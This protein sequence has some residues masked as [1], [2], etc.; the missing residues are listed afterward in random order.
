M[1]EA[2]KDHRQPIKRMLN[3][4]NGRRARMDTQVSIR[5]ARKEDGYN[6]RRNMAA[7]AKALAELM[8]KEKSQMLHE[9]AQRCQALLI[10]LKHAEADVRRKSLRAFVYLMSSGVPPLF[11]DSDPQ[12]V[13]LWQT[14]LA[15]IP[16]FVGALDL[17]DVSMQSDAAFALRFI[18]SMDRSLYVVQSGV[19]PKM[20]VLLQCGISELQIQAAWCLGNVASESKVMCEAVVAVCPPQTVL[21]H[22]RMSTPSLRRASVWLLRS[23]IDM[24]ELLAGLGLLTPQLEGDVMTV[25]ANVMKQLVVEKTKALAKEP[26]APSPA[27]ATWRYFQM[28]S[29]RP[30]PNDI[31]LVRLLREIDAITVEVV[32]VDVNYETGE[33]SVFTVQKSALR[34]MQTIDGDDDSAEAEDDATESLTLDEKALTLCDC[35][36]AIIEMTT[37]N[38]SLV[39]TFVATGVLPKLVELLHLYASPMLLHPLLQLLGQILAM[40]ESLAVVALEAKLLPALPRVLNSMSRSIREET[41]WILAH[42]TTGSEALLHAVI[43]T[44]GVVPAILEQLAWAEYDVKHEAAWATCSLLVRGDGNV[45]GELVRLGALVSLCPL[46][47]KYE[48]PAIEL[49]VLEAIS[50][51][52]NVGQETGTIDSAKQAV[53]ESGCVVAI[54]DLCYDEND[55]VSAAASYVMDK[56]FTGDANDDVD[57][58]LAPGVADGELTFQPA[59]GPVQFDFTQK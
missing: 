59:T 23:M 54:E 3:G 15:A 20:V 13:P 26:A 46:L 6:Q 31:V 12:H 36:W 29:G 9:I 51:V 33:Y 10:G 25:L 45:I 55:D 43:E 21:P 49:A 18:A 44:P 52:L 41:C 5:K 4:V 7:Q 57:A 37:H 56:W 34:P 16:F 8:P 22:I 50:N 30:A 38:K 58:T 28:D 32:D 40:D 11:D 53:E 39:S 24:P 19:L 48:D 1:S 2:K 42:L 27:V 35:A 17:A 14:I 47:D